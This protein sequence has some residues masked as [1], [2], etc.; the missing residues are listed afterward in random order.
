MSSK[1]HH[2][3][4]KFWVRSFNAS[5]DTTL[6]RLPSMSVFS[7]HN[8]SIIGVSFSSILDLCEKPF[9]ALESSGGSLVPS[10]EI[11]EFSNEIFDSGRVE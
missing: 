7:N 1:N 4:P 6:P 3:A 10:R 5:N 2:L 9:L 11:A 8:R